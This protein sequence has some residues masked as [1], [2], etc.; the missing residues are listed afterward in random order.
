MRVLLSLMFLVLML[1]PPVDAGWFSKPVEVEIG[2]SHAGTLIR[3]DRDEDGNKSTVLVQIQQSQE[4][5]LAGAFYA[6]DRYGVEQPVDEYRVDVL[7]AGAVKS[8]ELCY[9]SQR[10]AQSLRR[11]LLKGDFGGGLDGFSVRSGLSQ[12]STTVESRQT[13]RFDSAPCM[14][15]LL[16]HGKMVEGQRLPLTFFYSE[17]TDNATIQAIES[18]PAVA[19]THFSYPALAFTYEITPLLRGADPGATGTLTFTLAQYHAFPAKQEGT[20]TIA[21][22]TSHTTLDL[23]GFHGGDGYVLP[24]LEHAPMPARNPAANFVHFEPMRLDDAAFQLPFPYADALASIQNDPTLHFS[25]FAGDGRGV[26]LFAAT[27]DQRMRDDAAPTADTDGGWQLIYARSA[28]QTFIVQSVRLRATGPVPGV[29]HNTRQPFVQ[30]T[31]QYPRWPPTEL[32]SSTTLANVAA[33][34]GIQPGSVQRLTWVMLSDG[35]Q[36]ALAR[37]SVSDVSEAQGTGATGKRLDFDPATGG[38]TGAYDTRAMTQNTGLLSSPS[39]DDTFAP[40]PASGVTSLVGPAFGENLNGYVAFTGFALLVLAIKF[41]LIP[42]FTRLRRDRLL[43]NPVR[44][45]LYERVRAEPGIHQAELVDIAGIGEGATR[46]HLRQ[47]TRNR[48][49]IEM[50]DE[51]FV[52]YFA[53]GEV[54]PHVAHKAAALRSKTA[55]AVYDLLLAE[56]HLSLRQAGSRLGMSA[57]SVHRTKKRLERSGL[58]PLKPSR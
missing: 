15:R 23:T 19:T 38:L 5:D 7:E 11:D 17:E 55:R 22:K 13:V 6:R 12:T 54:P 20:V 10:S 30:A 31:L 16:P 52:R 39:S 26:V 44:A 56:P 48:L 34:Y 32:A 37:L 25:D 51:G 18:L 58:L 1:A 42:L 36:P 28:D 43:D 8:S 41:L 27:F 47:L 24:R 57:P 3:F 40:R 50:H 9:A 14:A 33:A 35:A 2:D 46:Y 4:A 21:G 45:R 49:L 53:A 29:V